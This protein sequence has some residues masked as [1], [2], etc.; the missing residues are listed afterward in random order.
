MSSVESTSQSVD[1]RLLTN[2]VPVLICVLD[3]NQRYLFVNRGYEAL[4]GCPR[5]EI[6]GQLLRDKLGDDAYERIRPQVE[7]ALSGERVDFE[8]SFPHPSGVGTSWF[9]TS[10]VP[11]LGPDGEVGGF[12]SIARNVTAEKDAAA[13]SDRLKAKMAELQRLESLEVLA[14]GVAH[15]FNNLLATMLTHAQLARTM[16]PAGSAQDDDLKMIEEAALRASELSGQM[17]AHSGK[18]TLRVEPLR[19]SNLLDDMKSRI[20]GEAGLEVDLQVPDDLPWVEAD[21]SQLRQLVLNLVSNASEATGRQG[22]ATLRTGQ[23]TMSRNEL[24]ATV[25]DDDL[26][27]GRYVFLEIEDD[28]CGMDSE[29]LTR[30]FDPFFTTK[31]AGR[32]LGLGAVLGIV[33]SHGGAIE[34]RSEP[35]EGTR[36]R[37][38]LPESRPPEP[39]PIERRREKVSGGHVLIADDDHGVRRAAKRT[40]ERAGF[41]VHTVCNGLEAV[42]AVNANPEA[43]DV[44]LLD[45]TMPVMDGVETLAELRRIQPD[46][47]VVL[48]SGYGREQL[49]Q[50]CAGQRVDGLVTKPFTLDGLVN[51]VAG[52]IDR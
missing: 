24:A 9:A 20:V 50:R 19:L 2:A 11:F 3:T 46:L 22:R 38:L 12:Y 27:E 17:L 41:S 26:P 29:T 14:G 1:L 13:E 40:L 4:H 48:C 51:T 36:V 35:R 25:V 10:Y 45:L 6:E 21:A 33:R 34:L 44:A 31:F 43:F 30:S 16:V 49:H 15:D 8:S 47:P 32:G 18:G 39:V 28:G 42:E 5:E 7:A 23:V 52:V 37:V